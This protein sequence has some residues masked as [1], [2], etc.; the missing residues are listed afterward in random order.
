MVPESESPTTTSK[1]KLVANAESSPLWRDSWIKYL[2]FI[3]KTIVVAMNAMRY[4]TT[5]EQSAEF[6]ADD[7]ESHESQWVGKRVGTIDAS[8]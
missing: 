6:I 2:P 7:L 3:G 4:Q 5:L 8:Q 1:S